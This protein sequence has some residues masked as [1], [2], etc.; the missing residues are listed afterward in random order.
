[1][2]NLLFSSLFL[3]IEAVLSSGEVFSK[4]FCVFHLVYFSFISIGFRNL[5][6]NL[7][8]HSFANVV[9]IEFSAV[10]SN[11][12]KWDILLNQHK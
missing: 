6:S 11:A 4:Q 2:P 3:V 8:A 9:A 5:G 12:L 10:Y 7:N 1:V